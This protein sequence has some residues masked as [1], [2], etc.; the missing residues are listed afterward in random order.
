MKTIIE[1]Y[2]RKKHPLYGTW[3]NMRDRCNNPNNKDYKFYGAKGIK[4]CVAWN[5][6]LT[7]VEDLKNIGNKPEGFTLD[8]IDPAK[9]YLPENVQWSSKTKQARNQSINK[10]NKTGVSGVNK[11]KCGGYIARI[12]NDG[13]RL[14]LGYFKNLDDAV[15]ARKDKEKE[16]GWYDVK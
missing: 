7:F 9:D 12:R 1:G 14:Y 13:E 4:V 8:R 3:T 11:M 16:L 15:K 5:D 2:E 6:F 10:H